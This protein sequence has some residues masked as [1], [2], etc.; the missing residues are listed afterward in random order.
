[1][2]RTW[3]LALCLSFGV[4]FAVAQEGHP[5]IENPAN[6]NPEEIEA[7]YQKLKEEMASSYALAGE[8][9]ISNYQTW[10]R[11]NTSPF[12]SATHGNRYVNSFANAFGK[13]Y[14]RLPAGAKYPVQTVFAK[15]SITLTED[16]KI[17]PGFLFGMEKLSKNASSETGDWRY[18]VV[19]P[20]GSMYGDTT[21]DEPELVE[22]CHGCHIA[23]SESD[24]VFF[25]PDE[26]QI[27]N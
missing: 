13:D 19:G 23:R 2:F 16:G 10:K 15:E 6:L 25:V 18:F 24:F 9:S 5:T 12:V 27:K 8:V 17:L 26:F 22:Y 1:M 21:G 4:G 7:V 20:Y 11:Y 3:M 14:G